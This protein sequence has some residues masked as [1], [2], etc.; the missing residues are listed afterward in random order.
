M[1]YLCLNSYIFCKTHIKYQAIIVLK[2]KCSLRLTNRAEA[3]SDE[4]E[5]EE[6]ETR[7]SPCE[8][9][10]FNFRK[11]IQLNDASNEVYVIQSFC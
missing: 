2:V 9:P 10:Y 3:N 8:A 4:E 5:L 11:E 6:I 1:I 7:V